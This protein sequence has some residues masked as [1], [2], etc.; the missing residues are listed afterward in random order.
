MLK[1]KTLSIMCCSEVFFFSRINVRMLPHHFTLQNYQF[2]ITK[3]IT[4]FRALSLSPPV[5]RLQQILQ[6][7]GN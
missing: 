3:K 2:Q 5:P 7:C 6:W 4:N 1:K